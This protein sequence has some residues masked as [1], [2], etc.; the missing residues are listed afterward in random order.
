[1][2]EN[3]FINLDKKVFYGYQSKFRNHKGKNSNLH[4]KQK[5]LSVKDIIEAKVNRKL[6]M[7]HRKCS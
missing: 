7:M 4:E 3:Y 6:Y 5:Y 1:M 2:L